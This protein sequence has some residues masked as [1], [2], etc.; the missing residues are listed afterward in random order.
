MSETRIRLNRNTP[1]EVI[2]ASLDR[3]RSIGIDLTWKFWVKLVLVGT[4]P[5]LLRVSPDLPRGRCDRGTRNSTLRF[6]ECY[7]TI[8]I[9]IQD[10]TSFLTHMGARIIFIFLLE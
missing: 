3:A 9:Y 8:Y 1:M 5:K 6:R 7:A 4:E 2:K 10:R